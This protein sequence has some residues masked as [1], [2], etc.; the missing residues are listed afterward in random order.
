MLISA[1]QNGNRGA[2]LTPHQSGCAPKDARAKAPSAA[3]LKIGFVSVRTEWRITS[4]PNRTSGNIHQEDVGSMSRKRMSVVMARCS[5]WK[6][7]FG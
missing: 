1:P 6:M 3:G 7:I 5:C 4:T 2:K